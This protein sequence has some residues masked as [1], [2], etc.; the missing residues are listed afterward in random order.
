[1]HRITREQMPAQL[2]GGDAIRALL[3]TTVQS[4]LEAEIEEA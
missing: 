1:M 4:V 3:Q 2:Q